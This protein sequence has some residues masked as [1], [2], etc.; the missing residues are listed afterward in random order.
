MLDQAEGEVVLLEAMEAAAD[1]PPEPARLGRE[2][3]AGT[4]GV[5]QPQRL[6]ADEPER[7]RAIRAEQPLA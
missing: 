2:P 7:T 3:E 5:A 6:L 4:Y 1:A